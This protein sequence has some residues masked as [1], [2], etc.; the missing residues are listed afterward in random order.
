MDA[1]VLAIAA[2]ATLGLVHIER[3]NFWLD[4]GAA[5]L[6]KRQGRLVFFVKAT[7]VAAILSAA[8][9]PFTLPNAVTFVLTTALFSLH[10]MLMV[11]AS[12]EEGGLS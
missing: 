2:C 6:W 11:R 9:G 7:F 10:L 12:F 3:A 4:G 1:S 8:L 5:R